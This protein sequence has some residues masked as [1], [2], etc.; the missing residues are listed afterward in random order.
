[1]KTVITL[2]K[3][4]ISDDVKK[5]WIWGYWVSPMM[6]AMNGIAVNEFLGDKWNKPIN[7]TTLGK[8]IITARGLYAESYWYWIAILA[9]VGFIFLL[10][11]FF[12]LS[13]DL[14]NPFGRSGS[15]SSQNDDD[16]SPVELSQTSDGS[17]QSKKKGM[18][19]P[20]EPHS[21]TFNDV[22]YSVDMPQVTFKNSSNPIFLHLSL[23]F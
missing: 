16:K 7:G 15:V 19:L 2:I 12:G 13:L 20:F 8:T 9:S 5:W 14:L 1:M 21:I 18:I 23:L 17:N 11:L 22:K 3:Y 10:N 4:L 6:Y